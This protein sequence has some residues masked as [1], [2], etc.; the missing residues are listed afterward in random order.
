MVGMT[1]GDEDVLAFDH[2]AYLDRAGT[3]QAMQRWIHA[4]PKHT[5]LILVSGAPALALRAIAASGRK[6][7]EQVSVLALS[8]HPPP[9]S[10]SEAAVDV[11]EEISPQTTAFEIP[12]QAMAESAIERAV[13]LAD[14]R[15]FR[16][17]ERVL[18]VPLIHHL[19]ATIGRVSGG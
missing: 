3:I 10:P 19:G 14:G 17:V 5:A 16:E 8:D 1:F 2:F 4:H 12:V 6:V 15:T 7:P 11:D 18:Y 9:Q 13:R